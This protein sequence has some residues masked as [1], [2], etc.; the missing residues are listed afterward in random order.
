LIPLCDGQVRS[1]LTEYVRQ[2]RVG[3]QPHEYFFLNRLGARLSEPRRILSL[4][5]RPPPRSRS[6]TR[7]KGHF[8]SFR[9][10]VPNVPLCVNPSFFRV[11][12]RERGLRSE[13]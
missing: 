13:Q 12:E 7:S 11:S 9:I 8:L 10:R 6:R 3:R 1:A 2:R 4:C 5:R